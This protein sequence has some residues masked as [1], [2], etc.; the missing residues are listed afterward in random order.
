MDLVTYLLRIGSCKLS[1]AEKNLIEI[2]LLTAI[3]RELYE[4]FKNRYKDYLRLIKSSHDKEANMFRVSFAQE[5]IKD[6]LSTEEY[7]LS[8]IATHIHV[9]EEVLSDVA[10]GVNNNPT[11][12]LSR[13]IFELHVTVRRDLYDTMMQKIIS[14]YL[15][16]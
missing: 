11:F 10:S 1:K 13:K 7:S 15:T 3:Y 14:E 6:I 8:G 9:P 5:L 2:K 12:E 16:T 4:I